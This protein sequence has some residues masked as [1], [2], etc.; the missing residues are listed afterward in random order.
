MAHRGDAAAEYDAQG[1]VLV[2]EPVVDPS[3]VLRAI[4]SC[5]AVTAGI[6]A[7]GVAPWRRWNVG[8]PERVQKVDQAHLADDGIFALV[9]HPAIGAW[10]ARVTGARRVQLWATQLITKP[11]GGGALGHVG[12]HDDDQNW[13]FLEGEALTVWLAL[14]HVGPDA[15]PVRFL[16]GSHRWPRQGERGDAY[17][18]DLDGQR[19]RLVGAVAPERVV[20]EVDAVLPMGGLSLHDRYTLHCSGANRSPSSR[21]GIAINVRTE[22]SAPV[23][24]VDDH[25]YCSHLD[26]P[27][28]CPVLFEAEPDG[29]ARP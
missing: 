10:V 4:P 29:S 22:R 19:A 23:P 7:T 8:S 3:L 27:R 21:L 14:G 2:D 9:T 6:H 15:G 13:A 18:Q 12:W 16:P 11:P 28:I 17:D 25:G 5:A 24:G 1:F 26:D 20:P